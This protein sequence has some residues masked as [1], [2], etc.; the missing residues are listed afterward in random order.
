MFLNM[1]TLKKSLFYKSFA[2]K[3]E[4]LNTK[5]IIIEIYLPSINYLLFYNI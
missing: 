1:F 2:Q 5:L 4:L 3:N